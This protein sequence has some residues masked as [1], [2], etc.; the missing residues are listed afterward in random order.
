MNIKK[1]AERQEFDLE[2]RIL[3]LA[4][5][6]S[7]IKRFFLEKGWLAIA[8]LKQLSLFIPLFCHC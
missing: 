5:R 7:K 3:P 4:P 8:K 1:L 2:E 6:E